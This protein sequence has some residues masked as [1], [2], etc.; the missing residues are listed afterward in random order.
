MT[1]APNNA[2]FFCS[3]NI[4]WISE[5]RFLHFSAFFLQKNLV[6]SKKSSTFALAFEK[7]YASLAQS[8]RASDC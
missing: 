1:F 8:V 5:K 6:I 2:C 7:E 4:F 3:V